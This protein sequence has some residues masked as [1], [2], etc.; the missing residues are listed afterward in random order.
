MKSSNLETL[1]TC[2]ILSQRVAHRVHSLCFYP[3]LTFA[4]YLIIQLRFHQH[5]KALKNGTEDSLVPRTS[6]LVAN[7]PQDSSSHFDDLGLGSWV[8]PKE[9]LFSWE[10]S[11]RHDGVFFS[12]V[13]ALQASLTLFTA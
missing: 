7:D 3:V 12:Q 1:Q 8:I 9:I 6:D 11:M 2:K 13:A 10:K 5:S 4:D